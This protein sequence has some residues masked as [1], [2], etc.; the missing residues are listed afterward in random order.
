MRP[1][2]EIPVGELWL[3]AN[4]FPLEFQAGLL[5]IPLFQIELASNSRCP[6]CDRRHFV[7]KGVGDFMITTLLTFTNRVL[8][9]GKSKGLNTTYV[10]VAII[11]FGVLLIGIFRS[12]R[13]E[14]F[15]TSPAI[16]VTHEMLDLAIRA[17]ADAEDARYEQAIQGWNSL[18]EKVPGN[19]ELL[20]NLA[21]TVLKWIAESNSQLTSGAI[22]QPDEIERQAIELERAMVEADR[23]VSRLAESS[24]SDGRTAYLEAA[25]LDAKSLRQPQPNDLKRQAIDRIIQAMREDPANALLACKLDD[26]AQTAM[27][28]DPTL[29]KSAAD[30][31][32][33]SWRASP[34]NLYLLVRAGE[35]LMELEDARIVELLSPSLELAKPMMSMLQTRMPRRN[36]DAIVSEAKQAIQRG[37]WSQAQS[38]RLWFNVLKSSTAYRPD[39][40]LVKPDIMALLGT[41]FVQQWR[42][43]LDSSASKTP[44]FLNPSVPL[45]FISRS[46]ASINDRAS[47]A[48]GV[49][50]DYDLDGNFELLLG[51]GKTLR[52]YDVGSYHSGSYPIHE[53]DLPMDAAGL[54]VADL[55]EVD[56]ASRPR[57]A[58]T[59][60]E[61]MDQNMRG[62]VQAIEESTANRHDTI[63]EV[64][65]WS[66]SGVIVITS[67]STSEQS[68]KR[69]FKILASVDGL[70]DLKR[71]T[72]IV[73]LDFDSDGDLDLAVATRD[74]LR[75]L[76]NNGNR[77]FTDVTQFSSLPGPTWS[78]SSMA[79]GDFDRDLDLDVVCVASSEP[80]V[81]LLENIQHSQFRHLEL[82]SEHSQAIGTG[83]SV[84]IAEVDGNGS[85]DACVLGSSGLTTVYTRS[86]DDGGIVATRSAN[87]PGSS[88]G[89]LRIA[90]FDNDGLTDAVVADTKGLR[91]YRGISAGGF[92]NLPIQIIEGRDARSLAVAD[93]DQDGV[94][95]MFA[96]VDGDALLFT[97][98]S[99]PT[100]DF[101]QVRVRGI[102]DINGGGRI[103]H[104]SVGSVIELW[105]KGRFQAQVIRD[106][107]VHFGIGSTVPTNLRVVFNNGLTQN[108]ESVQANTLVQERQELKGSCPFVYGWDGN[109]FQL[110]TDLLWNAP[111]GLQIARGKVLPDRRWEHLILPNK[112]MQPCNS[113]YELRITE[114]LWEIAYFDHVSLT[115][116]DHP[117]DV[118]IFSNEKVGP[119]AIAHPRLFEVSSKIYPIRAVDQRG[120]DILGKLSTQDAD[121]AQA[122]QNQICQGLCEPHYIELDFGQIE[123]NEQARMYLTGWLQPTD[124]SLNIGIDQNKN[125][126]SPEPP[127][128]WVPNESDEFVCVN[129]Y[130]GFPGGKPKSIVVELGNIFLSSDH[131]LRIAGSQQIYWD[132]AFV[133]LEHPDSVLKTIPLQMTNAE[134]HFRGFSRL[135]PKQPDQPHW[136][137]YTQTAIEPKWPPLDG[138]YT[139]YGQV[140][141]LLKKDD[142]RMVI[143]GAGDEIVLHFEIPSEPLRKGWTR[144]F[145]LHNVGWDKDADVN[146]L[147]GQGTMPLPFQS[148][149]SYPAPAS[150]ADE[151]SKTM[152]LNAPY[153]IDR[154]TSPSFWK[155][156][157]HSPATH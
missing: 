142:D 61:L 67:E 15:E 57:V 37:Q 137:D 54:L 72:Q 24:D 28:E 134:L 105:S 34:R 80:L 7:G 119:A 106:P 79:V 11:L 108:V 92:N 123:F 25:L 26:L 59:V 96:I 135:M 75:F 69:T 77:T 118:E 91:L 52:L 133:V 93:Y 115:A 39:S 97:P 53:I 33:S 157:F 65:V 125:L 100:G 9:M 36:A 154:R 101:V 114:E 32:F 139:R 42:D 89:E 131:R 18:L 14:I 109:R 155:A 112:F 16:T 140:A 29:I 128:L 58:T 156:P 56:T 49:W 12:N 147:S 151:E 3:Y 50:Y 27:V 136:Y 17:V 130:I 143:M 145:V 23:T 84:A 73:P 146:T 30:A 94:L 95:D 126:R 113:V 121:Y 43:S 124:T 122:F 110:I 62:E 76:Q 99:R 20:I 40:R 78:P 44:L 85:W 63:Q 1:C 152:E 141:E 103:N 70:S 64:I 90:D 82:R 81:L 88:E 55:F 68:T 19:R 47:A 86:T 71:V 153:L 132:E 150:Q 117:P 35:N 45:E 60:V 129:P 107:V 83:T 22:T 31:L 48:I 98:C 13:V 120:R 102:N 66:E 149:E 10:V 46:L 144:D 116:V 51:S 104:Y 111:L 74:G 6:T 5:Q 38:L 127:S 21:A 87:I 138:P 4:A 148:M 41:R 2:F 8:K